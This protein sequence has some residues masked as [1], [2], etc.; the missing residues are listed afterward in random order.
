MITSSA[1]STNAFGE[2]YKSSITANF[3]TISG[4]ISTVGKGYSAGNGPGYCSGTGAGE[5][6]GE[7]SGCS[8]QTYGSYN[9]PTNIGSGGSVVSGGGAIILTSGCNTLHA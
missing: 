2:V 6:G 4:L 1:N 3:M 7:T 5:Y 8:N 9:A